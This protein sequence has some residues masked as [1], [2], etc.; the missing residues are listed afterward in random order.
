MVDSAAELFTSAT[1][2]GTADISESA[3]GSLLFFW[4]LCRAVTWESREVAILVFRT[5]GYLSTP[6]HS[7]LLLLAKLSLFCRYAFLQ[8]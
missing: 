7:P 3:S 6:Y 2:H 8:G 4:L 5:E 1:D